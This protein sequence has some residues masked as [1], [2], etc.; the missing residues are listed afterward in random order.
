MG[1]SFRG[2]AFPGDMICR[3]CR[4]DCNAGD[5]AG[6]WTDECGRD[7]MVSGFGAARTGRIVHDVVWVETTDA[8]CHGAIAT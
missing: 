5:E 3:L 1:V 2:K 6:N 7:E 8:G 4:N